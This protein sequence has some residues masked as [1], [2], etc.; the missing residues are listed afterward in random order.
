MDD[1]GEHPVAHCPGRRGSVR[2][3]IRGDCVDRR[4]PTDAKDVSGDVPQTHG[5]CGNH[6]PFRDSLDD[7]VDW[8]TDLGVC[9]LDSVSRPR[10]D[11]DC[12]GNRRATHAWGLGLPSRIEGCEPG[13]RSSHRA[14]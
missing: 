5:S 3:A 9:L 8:I 1:A 12:R 13:R 4:P 6:C 7:W 14:S 10:I 2:F 11:R